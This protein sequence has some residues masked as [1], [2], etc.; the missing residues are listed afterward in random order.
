MGDEVSSAD[1]SGFTVNSTLNMSRRD[2]TQLGTHRSRRY[3]HSKRLAERSPLSPVS[4]DRRDFVTMTFSSGS[5]SGK[6]TP[7]SH[8]ETDFPN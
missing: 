5:L 1:I 6:P 8:L 3:N 4:G 2:A 7:V